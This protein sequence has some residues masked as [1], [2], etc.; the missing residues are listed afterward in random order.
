[1]K[2]RNDMSGVLGALLLFASCSA[3][4]QWGP[5]DNTISVSQSSA[6]YVRG[7]GAYIVQV[8]ATN[9]S[10]QSIHGPFRVLVDNASLTVKDAD[11]QT[12]EGVP[13]F[14]FLLGDI[15]PG[16]TISVNVR[17]EYERRTRLT[18]DL[19]IQSNAVLD[20]DND[21]VNDDIDQCLETPAGIEV[22]ETGCSLVTNDSDWTLVWSDEFNG[23]VIDDTKWTHEVNCDGGGNNEKQCYTDNAENA[24]LE[25]G[26][27]KIVAKAESNQTLPYSSARLIS[28]E[29]GD[30]TYGRFEIRA[31]APSGQGA[32]PAIWMLPTD[33]KYGGWPHS[34]EI[35]IF[36]AVNLGV[37]LNDDSGAVESNVH[38][39]LHY[40]AS[41][42]NNSYT[43][44]SY[45]LPNAANPANDFHV[46][47]VEWEEGEIRWYVDGVLYQTQLKSEVSY[48]TDGQAD[49]LDHRGWFTEQDGENL[50]NNAPFDE[51]FHLLLNFAVGGS[52]PE[53]VN[54]GGVDSSAFD[55]QNSF[56][57]DYVRV[58]ECSISPSTGEGCATVTDN[59]LDPIADGG[60]LVNG[61]APVP[62][63][64]SDGIAR[65]LIIFDDEMLPTWP[66]WDCCGDTSPRVVFDDESQSQVVE[67]EVNG[68]PA[69][70][71][72]NTNQA[73]D[74]SPFDAS[75]MYEAGVLEF[76]LK[77]V[78]PPN[79]NAAGWNLK[80][81][82]GGAATAGEIS[83]ATPTAAWQHYSVPLKSLSNAGLNLNGIDIVMLFPDWGQ[84]EG[85]VF[86]VDNVAF[87]QSAD[88]GSSGGEV[89]SDLTAIDF[90]QDGFGAS[91]SWNVFENS[92]N[93]PIELVAN[94]D[95]SGINGSST[96]AKITA[97]V[98]GA[99]WVG[100]EIQHGQ[101]TPFTLDASNS[102]V[103]IMVYK[104]VISDVGLKF[105]I[106]SGGAQ[107]E[108]KVANQKINEWEELTFDFSDYIGLVEAIDIDQIIV[109]PDFDFSTR[110]QDNTVY[111]DNIRFFGS[112]D[113]ESGGGDDGNEN[114]IPVSELVN[115][116][117]FTNGT[118]G[119]IG[120]VN[121]ITDNGNN[122]F[123]A[124]VAAAGNPWDVNL[125]QV[126]TL[127]PGETYELTFKAKASVVRSVIAGLGLNHDPWSNVT[128][129]TAL[130]TQWQ[131]FTYILTPTDF[132]DDNSRVFFDLGAETGAVYIDDVSVTV[133]DTTDNGGGDQG[134]SSDLTAF[135]FEAQG[136]GAQLNWN[137]FENGD[138]SPLEFV[139]N[140][141]PSGINNSST[142][143]K[144]TAQVEGAPWVGTEIQHGQ[145]TP[146][147]LDPSN[148]F[149]KIMV[150]KSVLSDVGIKFAIAN[151]GAQ[152]E[153]KVANTKINEWEELT[154]DFSGYI[155]LVEAIDIDQII[156]F[157]DFDFNTRAQNNVVYFDNIRLVD[158]NDAGS[159]DGNGGATGSDVHDFEGATYAFTDFD[160]GVA[161][162]AANP[163]MSGINT[164]AQVGQM[165][166][167]AGQPW[168]GTTLALNNPID[169]AENTVITLKV[170]SPRA[171][172][173]LLKLEGGVV[174]EIS[175]QHS[176]LGWEELSFDFS[177]ITGS[178]TTA[179]TLI[180]DLGEMGNA[181]AD[182]ANWTFYFD[183]LTLPASSDEG[184]GGDNGNDADNDGV[185]DDIDQCLNTP[186][187]SIVDATGCVVNVTS[188][189]NLVWNDEFNGTSIDQAKWS[190]EVNCDG[191]GNNEKQCY[192]AS[193]DNSFVQNGLLT[194]VA[195][196]ETGQPLPYSSARLISKNK[197]DWT[198]GRFEIRAKAPSG[199]GS[200]PAIWMLPTDYIYGGWPH[201]GEIDIFEAVNLGVPLND[202]TGAV[203]SNVH[204][205]I[206]YGQSWPNNDNSGRSYA[207][208]ED[209]NPADDFHI[210]ALEWEEGE[211]RWYVDGV[212]YETQRKSTVSYD[213]NGTANGLSHRG[214]YTEQSGETLWNNA[215]FDERFH[216]LLN[217]AVGGAW[218]EAVNQGGVDASA[219]SAAN[220]F[221]VD[222][223]RVY[224]CSTSPSNGHGCATVTDGYAESVANGGTLINGAAPIPVPE[225]DG[226]ARDL[227]IFDDMLNDA[228]PAWDC[229]GESTP[230][231]V[232][233]D[234]L[235]SQVIEFAVGDIPT[236]LGFNTTLATVPAPFDA[237][238]IANSGTLEFDLKLVTPSTNT[239]AA[240][241]LKV[242]QGGAASEAVVTLV[243][244]TA[245][246]QHYSIALSTLKQGGL[247]LNGID[248][249]MLF[250]DW[251]QGE[252][253][254]FRVDNVQFLQGEDDG[255]GGDD[256]DNGGGVTDPEVGDELV[257]NG[258]FDNGAQG[259]TGDVNVIQEASNYVFQADIAAAGNSWDVNLSQVM[260][261]TA[262][263]TYV[264]TFKAKASI[265][266]NIVV[267]LGLNHDPWS[268]VT[269][270]A[271]LTT[272]WQTFSYTFT[273]NGFGDD[274]SRVFFDLGADIGIV[275][276]DDVSV[277]LQAT[278]GGGDG[279]PVTED[280][281]V[282]I[283]ATEETD[284]NFA[285]N[286]VSE[287][288]TGTTLQ[289]DVMFDGLRGWELI[290]S[291]NSPEQGNWGS[292]LAF[293]NGIDGDFSLFNRINLKVATTGYYAGGYK[294]AISANGVS[295]EIAIPVNESVSTWQSITLDTKAIPLNLSKVDWIAVY[296]I[297]GQAG[298]SRIYVTDFS[299]VKDSAIEFE[300]DTTN[301][302]VFISS[303]ASIS[304]DLIV[305]ND[306]YSDVGNVIFGEWS[307]GTGISNTQY[308]GLNG[309]RLSAGG[310]W[311]AVLALQGDISD[312]NSIDN[313]D[314][315]FST[316]TNLRFKAASQGAF[317]RYAVSIVSAIEGKESA[318]EV[319]FALTN[320]A[321]WN[322]IDIDLGMYGVDLSNVS[323]IALFGVYDGGSASQSLYI[324]DLVMYDS[325]KVALSDKDSSDDKFVFF[326]SSGEDSDML[327]DGDD[328]AHNGNMTIGEWSTGTSFNSDVM[329]NGLSAFELV[330]GSGSW[331]AVLALAGD[332]YGDVQ[333][334]SID[335]AAYQTLN[336]K[337]AA[338]GGFSEYTLDFVVDGSEHKVPLSVNSNWNEVTINLADIPL[339]LSKLTQIAIFGVGGGQGNRIYI[340]DM[341]LSK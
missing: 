68:A 177:G 225:S 44:Q 56:D 192:T 337:I 98:A 15:A 191:G 31:K 193:S 138:N 147:T 319:G 151:G 313:Y 188:D 128:Q 256:G 17:F 62:T 327:F 159:D 287:W 78:T 300:T 28:K 324:T 6:R 84:G 39:T 284:I 307:T 233:D 169:I 74:P 171:V 231:V 227:V 95:S 211:L 89:E 288:S 253:A 20:E 73:T 198:Y 25:N 92:D 244:P 149:V 94:P 283:S 285:P 209:A 88:E 13:Y 240:W 67:F 260:T 93:P 333:Q 201:S 72:F 59:Y 152:G 99:P 330:R 230:V 86:R 258:S 180:F 137:V 7:E 19:V 5:L 155:G 101:L 148:S 293:Q 339:N 126:L 322:D 325:G 111:F 14:D 16:E 236:V 42:P 48:D 184:N 110:A 129:T 166:K 254:V 87:L 21:G 12:D 51:R 61:A 103:K 143:A 144:L 83:I 223:V 27:L 11:G 170:W 135:D 334:Y 71:G 3:S 185:A 271:A 141:N 160:G 34:G 262:G 212:L 186:A 57:V 178:G 139:S 336:F 217:F 328:Y 275:Q 219:F 76:D 112:D 308:N 120:A 105:A 237:S 272:D 82:Q 249:V 50:L 154:F 158:S 210:Y 290:S 294:V 54:Q 80:V 261:L 197:G 38:G 150:Y 26:I 299:L 64:P 301:D 124:D 181:E 23:S 311:G 91:L 247:M 134:G 36:E 156:V 305:D 216:L 114:P 291:S 161:T 187:N 277:V 309:L 228:W 276:I 296:G 90:E 119:W 140:P 22:D 175:A 316:Y 229:C 106:A 70:L 298:V 18:F 127:V 323:Q 246:W 235:Q 43:G 102:L 303:D 196:P 295:K 317:E 204:G 208:P 123:M 195:K 341:H 292:V 274:N 222:Y 252:G 115:N 41:W 306:N 131:T 24:Y 183:D 281:F 297:G 32:W 4:A 279:E 173:V 289:S 207:L 168:G 282:L 259:W 286:T 165:Q 33:Y 255:T 224:E 332:I 132:G 40:G 326:S 100:A 182:P 205:T 269:E 320:Q 314:T 310:S 243:T 136:F 77:L 63:A 53:A 174:G 66:A 30:W 104:S 176:G 153:I 218:P 8:K 107:G 202:G 47:A 113:D 58:Y 75:P 35:D 248:V 167:F 116:G 96:V 239:S 146:F 312:G 302:F 315:D 267:G 142:V 213:A 1:M 273:V 241:N 172:N 164:S 338:A 2:I 29:K 278:N 263:E 214:W 264:V 335:V 162:I 60:T 189:W 304:V 118:D 157:P 9:S 200:W 265:L 10:A 45:A 65:D 220:R 234:E 122:V 203:E 117:D 329:Y 221:E 125:S 190:H 257:A 331:G 270:N 69:V 121:V 81:E 163:D 85:A 79:N 242:E 321:D 55:G 245:N 226:I 145:I 97:R 238:P 340:T 52:W 199:Q 109:F 318:Q 49:G 194:I 37:P 215:P 232:F 133:K 268:N 280:E 251:G 266:R 206:H 250:P 46:Y 179:I 130:S 108:L